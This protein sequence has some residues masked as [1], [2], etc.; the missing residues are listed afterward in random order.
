MIVTEDEN[1]TA[2]RYNLHVL[3][4]DR[5][6]RGLATEGGWRLVGF[7]VSS[8]N[9]S[10]SERKPGCAR[11]EGRGGG[12]IACFLDS[13][14]SP[15]GWRFYGRYTNSRSLLLMGSGWQCGVEGGTFSGMSAADDSK[16]ERSA[17]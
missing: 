7:W 2:G 8:I 11:E 17:F 12:D 16:A 1:G 5:R 13:W 10:V 14:P 3:C 6:R 4:G 15:S 9:R